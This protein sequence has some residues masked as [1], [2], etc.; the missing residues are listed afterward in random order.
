[1]P[2][3]QAEAKISNQA[4]TGRARRCRRAADAGNQGLHDRPL[5]APFLP[6]FPYLRSGVPR[7]R[8]IGWR[9]CRLCARSLPARQR[10]RPALFDSGC[11]PRRG[12]RIAPPCGV[13]RGG[14]RA[15]LHRDT[16][17]SCEKNRSAIGL[18]RKAGYQTFARAAGYYDDGSNALRFEKRLVPKLAGLQSPPP[19]FHQTTEFTC[20]SACMMMALAFAKPAWRPEAASEFEL[21]RKATTIFTSGGPGGCDP[22]GLAVTLR[23]QGL[24]PEILVNNP[25]PYS[26]TPCGRKKNAVSC[27]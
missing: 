21:W 6:E 8:R 1:M 20:G 15:R 5:L 22:Y 10:D 7:C 14:A 2:A 27:V 9:S 19:Y 23:R 12:D 4:A 16:A 17:R 25:G 24:R 13:R 26:S 18:Y 3:P 11:P